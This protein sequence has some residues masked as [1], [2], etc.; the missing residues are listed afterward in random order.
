MHIFDNRLFGAKNLKVFIKLAKTASFASYS[1]GKLSLR[2]RFNDIGNY[3]EIAK[4]VKGN[5]P[6]IIVEFR[7]IIQENMKKICTIGKS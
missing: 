7:I 3:T 5:Q 4:V 6:P 1:N 2:P